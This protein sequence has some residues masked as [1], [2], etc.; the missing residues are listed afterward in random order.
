MAF[1]GVAVVT[2]VSDS[3][4]RVTGVSL[5]PGASGTISLFEGGAPVTLPQYVDWGTY[6]DVDLVESISIL[7]NPTT[8]P[9]DG[10]NFAI[11]V[12]VVKTGVTRATWV[13]TFTNDVPP[14]EGAP[15][16]GDLE[17]YIRYH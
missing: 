16:T 2:R 14:D 6:E 11:P 7:V 4:Y 9:L 1:T 5:Q 3:L 17:I 13:A 8:E 10:P 12:R 15:A